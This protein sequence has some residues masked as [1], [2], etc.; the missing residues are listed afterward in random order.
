M[1]DRIREKGIALTEYAID[2]HDAWL[3]PLGFTLGSPRDADRRGAHV[4]VRHPD[5]RR[6]CPELIAAGVVPDFR[7]PD[8]IRL[9]L[10]PLTTTFTDVWTGFGRLREFAAR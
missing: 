2:L 1:I 8:S 3:A 5:A 4:A 7:E 9:G 6:L 10:S